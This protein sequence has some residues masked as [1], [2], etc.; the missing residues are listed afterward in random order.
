MD[1]PCHPKPR[2]ILTPPSPYS[3]LQEHM[4]TL[5]SMGSELSSEERNVSPCKQPHCE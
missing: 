1:H 3:H 5:V 4:K 2:E